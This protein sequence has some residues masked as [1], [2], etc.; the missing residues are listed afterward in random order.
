MLTLQ[1][2]FDDLTVIVKRLSHINLNSFPSARMSVAT[3][4][5]KGMN[6]PASE[7]NCKNINIEIEK[8]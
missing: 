1:S 8:G 5:K 2:L 7:G 4:T 6:H 3:E